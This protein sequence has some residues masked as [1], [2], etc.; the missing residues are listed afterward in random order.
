MPNENETTTQ[1]TPQQPANA[2]S[3]DTVQAGQTG[4]EQAGAT[5][6]AEQP[7]VDPSVLE[8]GSEGDQPFKSAAVNLASPQENVPEDTPQPQGDAGYQ[9]QTTPPE[10]LDEGQRSKMETEAP[11]QPPPPADTTTTPPPPPPENSNKKPVIIALAVILL[12]VL[13]GA[14]VWW[15][16]QQREPESVVLEVDELATEDQTPTIA[17]TVS[18]HD[19]DEGVDVTVDGITYE[20]AV[21]DEGWEA[22][23]TEPLAPGSYDVEAGAYTETGER[24]EV[25]ATDAITIESPE[26]EPVEANVDDLSTEDDTPTVEGDITNVDDDTELVVVINGEEYAPVIDPAS[27]RWQVDVTE[28]LTPGTYDVIITVTAPEAMADELVIPEAVTIEEPE[29]EEESEPEPEEEEEPDETATTGPEDDLANTGGDPYRTQ[30][31]EDRE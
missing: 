29:P 28:P 16:F 18:G 8:E 23:V 22:D 17:G 5:A 21:V 27:G 12:L 25:E 11:P 4:Q 13:I 1:Q 6:V 9:P 14:G 26:P 2:G 31:P 3:T 19:E 15:W 30:P 20:A 7:Q 24:E 10:G